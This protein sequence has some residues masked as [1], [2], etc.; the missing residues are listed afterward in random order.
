MS[1]KLVIPGP[2]DCP[3]LDRVSFTVLVESTVRDSVPTP[4]LGLDNVSHS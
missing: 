4:I 2:Y 3:C 1:R